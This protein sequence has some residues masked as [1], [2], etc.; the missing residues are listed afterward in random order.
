M[1]QPRGHPTRRN[2]DARTLEEGC[3]G[4]E[5][6]RVTQGRKCA[7][8]TVQGQI[9]LGERRG[10]LTSLRQPTQRATDD[11]PRQRDRLIPLRRRITISTPNTITQRHGD[12]GS[13]DEYNT[14]SRTATTK[15]ISRRHQQH[16]TSTLHRRST[17]ATT[18]PHYRNIPH[19]N[20]TQHTMA[21]TTSP[22]QPTPP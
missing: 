14:R 5:L 19:S 16:A 12:Y 13:I 21:R 20:V 4:G 11:D 18:H 15:H 22:T 7:H 3:L 10:H 17:T 9:R 2:S 1:A 6:S 8:E